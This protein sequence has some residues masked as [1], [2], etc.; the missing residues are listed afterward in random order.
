MDWQL[1][2]VLG[3]I[4]PF[5]VKIIVSLW[6]PTNQD[7]GRYTL[8]FW[9]I[10]SPFLRWSNGLPWTQIV[11]VSFVIFHSPPLCIKIQQI[12][13]SLFFLCAGN[14]GGKKACKKRLPT[15]RLFV[16]PALFIPTEQY[17]P[18]KLRHWESVQM[19]SL[20]IW[21]WLQ[22]LLKHLV[23]LWKNRNLLGYQLIAIFLEREFIATPAG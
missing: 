2:R 16:W 11:I 12:P 15:G 1:E 22:K 18:L 17:H 5:C 14:L 10:Y 6:H 8:R 7:A 20:T 3:F 21:L 13:C 9:F 4:L 19:V 23:L